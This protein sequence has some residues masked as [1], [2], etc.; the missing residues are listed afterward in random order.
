MASYSTVSVFC[1]SVK[2]WAPHLRH[3]PSGS[4]LQ[5]YR[6][7]DYSVLPHRLNATP[8]PT[9]PSLDP[10]VNELQAS[11]GLPRLIEAV[12]AARIP[13]GR[14]WHRQVLKHCFMIWIRFLLGCLPAPWASQS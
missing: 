5:P 14:I 10:I 2:S 9:N 6:G 3:L 13:I 11:L 8:L 1:Y 12:R 7:L 4:T